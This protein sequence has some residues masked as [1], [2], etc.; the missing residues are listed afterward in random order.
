MRCTI[1]VEERVRALCKNFASLQILC[2]ELVDGLNKAFSDMMYVGWWKDRNLARPV[3]SDQ[4]FV[5]FHL[6]RLWNLNRI[7]DVCG[8]NCFCYLIQ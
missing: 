4:C 3:L 7:C 6:L 1:E 5:E 8:F 2:P